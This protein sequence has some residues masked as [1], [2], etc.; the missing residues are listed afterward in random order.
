VA[1]D[2][3]LVKVADILRQTTRGV[4]CVSRYGGEEFLVVLLE[5]T[6]TTAAIVAERI[7]ARVEAE[8]FAGG[9][10]TVSVGIAECPANG[11]T[12]E[13]L[14]ESADSAMYEAKHGGRN[15]VAV[16]GVTQEAGN[17]RRVRR[18]KEA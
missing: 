10:V 18:K 3:A 15:R 4:D 1:G 17:E 5:T 13:S 9:R 12:P 6:M 14:I 16:A 8:P 2:A 7:R 11:D